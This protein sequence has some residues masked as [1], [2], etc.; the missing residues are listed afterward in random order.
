MVSRTDNSTKSTVAQSDVLAWAREQ[1][2]AAK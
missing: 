1:L 2:A